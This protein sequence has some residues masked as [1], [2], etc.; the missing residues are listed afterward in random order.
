M[1]YSVKRRRSWLKI[2]LLSALIL[3]FVG[4]AS[5]AVI[6]RQRYVANLQPLDTSGTKIQKT[7]VIESG[8]TALQV[9]QKL[10]SEGIIRA[11]WAFEWYLR[12][13]ELRDKIQAGTY[14]LSATQSVSEIADVVT[15]GKVASEL[16]RVLPGKRL[17]QI[18]QV[19][20]DSGYRRDEVEAAFDPKNHSGH[21][22]LL[23]KPATSSLEGY[24]YPESY[25]VTA[26]TDAQTVVRNALDEL[27]KQL[28]PELR[29]GIAK[30]G[31]TVHEALVIASIIEQEVNNATDR[32]R[33]AQVFLTRY[34]IGMELGSDPTAFYASAIEGKPEVRNVFYDSPYNTRVY[35]GL[36]P[37][38]IGSTGVA[39]LKAVANPAA[40]DF[41]YFVAGD[42]GTTHFS[43]TLQEHEA[44]TRQY[45]T[46]LCGR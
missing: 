14:S 41:L 21:A 24:I 32:P 31:L 38:P 7:I 11:S 46:K 25:Q 4:L 26:N 3:L 34:R 10:E 2:T 6:V 39:S 35:K 44:L 36:P 40:G 27:Q 15:E 28:T 12:A 18:K 42:D 8:T 5:G 29:A 20:M 16:L 13:N 22:A 43:R 17:D 33:V 23:D 37:G 9:A 30:Q 19:F 1:K 45:C